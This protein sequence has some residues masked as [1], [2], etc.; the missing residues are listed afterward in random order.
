MNAFGY[1]MDH[2]RLW[3]GEDDTGDAGMRAFELEAHRFRREIPCEALISPAEEA[4]QGLDASPLADT[5]S[6]AWQLKEC[7]PL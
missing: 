6:S 1:L 7:R 4:Y 2:R 5:K 3:T